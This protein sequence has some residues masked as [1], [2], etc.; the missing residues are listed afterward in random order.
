MA[1]KPGESLYKAFKGEHLNRREALIAGAEGIGGLSALV[2]GLFGLS[3]SPAHAQSDALAA[4]SPSQPYEA[5]VRGDF[6]DG[7]S[8]TVQYLDTNGNPFLEV[9]SRFKGQA[10]K[11]KYNADV[12]D[13]IFRNI[14][15]HQIYFEECRNYSSRRMGTPSRKSKDKIRQRLGTDILGQ[16]QT[17]VRNNS[18]V[19]DEKG[20]PTSFR[21]EYVIKL[22]NKVIIVKI[23]YEYRM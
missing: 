19:G 5:K 22:R 20:N 2:D 13:L 6:G 12:Y 4:T 17:L 18:W 11:G 9:T 16:K 3:P 21:R 10:Q 23:P 15:N 8:F 1:Y 14:S 7:R